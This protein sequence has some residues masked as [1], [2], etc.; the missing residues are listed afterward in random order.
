MQKRKNTGC[1]TYEASLRGMWCVALFALS[2]TSSAIS[3]MV[4]GLPCVSH[5]GCLA[6]SSFCTLT[7]FPWL[8]SGRATCVS[9]WQCCLFPELYGTE[10]CSSRCRCRRDQPCSLDFDCG[11]GEFCAVLLSR[12]D[13]PVCQ[14]CHLCHNDAQAWRGSCAAACPSAALDDNGIAPQL[15]QGS[16]GVEVQYYYVFAA[17]DIAGHPLAQTGFIEASA[18]NGGLV[19]VSEAAVRTWLGD[20]P[21]YVQDALLKP[22][23][24]SRIVPLGDIAARLASVAAQRD[25][26]CPQLQSAAAATSTA[27]SIIAATVPEGCP[28][29]ATANATTFRCPAGQRCSRRAWLSLPADII[30]LGATALLK[31]R[32]VACEPGSYCPEGTYVEEQD[33]LD[34]MAGVYCPKGYYC[35]TPAQKHECPAGY[36]CPARSLTNITCDYQKLIALHLAS[37]QDDVQYTQA[38]VQR[39]ADARMPLRGGYCPAGSSTSDELC[40]AGFFCP[41]PSQQ[42]ICP[43]GHYCRAESIEPRD[44]PHLMLCPAG[45]SAPR[46]WPAAVITFCGLVLSV[47]MMGYCVSIMYDARVQSSLPSKRDQDNRAAAARDLRKFIAHFH[48]G[49]LSRTNRKMWRVERHVLDLCKLKWT[50]PGKAGKSSAAVLECVNGR[51]EDARLSAILGPSG[52]GKSSLLTLLAGRDAHWPLNDGVILINGVKAVSPRDLKY[53]TGFVPQDDIL[54]PELTVGEMINFSAALRLPNAPFRVA[55]PIATTNTGRVDMD[56]SSWAANP[57]FGAPISLS[58]YSGSASGY[59]NTTAPLQANGSSNKGGTGGDAAVDGGGRGGNTSYVGATAGSTNKGQDGGSRSK[60]A[61]ADFVTYRPA[62]ARRILVRD[63]LQMLDLTML[64]DQLVGSVSDKSLSGGQRKRVNIGVELVAR[65]PVLLLDEPTSGLDAAC[66]SDVLISLS[67]V[68]EDHGVNVIMAVHQ[69]RRTI[70]ALFN[71]LMLLDRHGR[72]VYHGDPT[73]ALQYFRSLDYKHLPMD[74]NVADILLD[75]VMGKYYSERYESDDLPVMMEPSTK[76]RAN[77][78]AVA[79]DASESVDGPKAASEAD[80]PSSSADA[81]APP[82]S[83]LPVAGTSAESARP[84]GSSGV[85]L[86]GFAAARGSNIRTP[87]LSERLVKMLR[88]E[89][90]KILHEQG[91]ANRGHKLNR[92]QLRKVFRNFGQK[93]PETDDFVQGILEEAI[94]QRQHQEQQAQQVQYLPQQQELQQRQPDNDCAGRGLHP[95]DPKRMQ[96][97]FAQYQQQFQ[98]QQHNIFPSRSD[99]PQAAELGRPSVQELAVSLKELLAVFQVVLDDKLK[100]E[101]LQHVKRDIQIRKSRLPSGWFRERADS[102]NLEGMPLSARMGGRASWLRHMMPSGPTK[103][104]RNPTD[105]AVAGRTL[106]L[107]SIAEHSAMSHVTPGA[108]ISGAPLIVTWLRTKRSVAGGGGGGGGGRRMLNKS[109]STATAGGVRK[110]PILLGCDQPPPPQQQQQQSAV[111]V[112]GRRPLLQLDGRPPHQNISLRVETTTTTNI[113]AAPPTYPGCAGSNHDHR[114]SPA[115]GNGHNGS[116]SVEQGNVRS[117]YHRTKSAGGGPQVLGMTNCQSVSTTAKVA[118]EAG[119]ASAASTAAAGS[120]SPSSS[121]TWFRRMTTAKLHASWLSQFITFTRRAELQSAR[122]FWSSSMLEAGL[123]MAAAAAVG[124]NQGPD[125]WGPTDV[126]GR[127]IMAM[128]CLAVLAVVQHLSSFSSNSLVLQRERGMGLDVS[129]YF[130]AR[131]VADLPWILIAPVYFSLP[132][133]ILTVPRAPYLPSYYV[134]SL[135]VWWWASGLSY[136]VTVLPLIPAAAAPTAAVLLTLISGALL[137]GWSSPTLVDARG[138]FTEVVLGLSYNR[139]AVET[140]TISELEKYM[141][142]H[143]NIIAAMYSKKGIC[144]LDVALSDINA[145]SF[146]T[147][148]SDAKLTVMWDAIF[149]WVTTPSSSAGSGGTDISTTSTSANS[150]SFIDGLCSEARRD[151]LIILF[152]LGLGLRILAGLTLKFDA[153]LV[154]IILT[155]REWLV[156]ARDAVAAFCCCCCRRWCCPRVG[157]RRWRWQCCFGMDSG[158]TVTGDDEDNVDHAENM[159]DRVVAAAIAAASGA[160]VVKV[161]GD[162]YSGGAGASAEG[163]VGGCGGTADPCRGTGSGLFAADCQSDEA[164][165]EVQAAAISAAA[166]L[167]CCIRDGSSVVH[168]RPLCDL[169]PSCA[170]ATLPATA[171]GPPL[172][173]EQQ[174]QQQQ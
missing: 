124:S 127:I 50:G 85:L 161:Q 97:P 103:D 23:T 31:A 62:E 15:Q 21:T 13:L 136:W 6:G 111:A 123:L 29:N 55:S 99:L 53:V 157:W 86:S 32:C 8:T 4:D 168:D 166:D 46:V 167:V 117:D 60:C 94:R 67:D 149:K 61:K 20:L 72:T 139:W 33:G 34:F 27:N 120:V 125:D 107:P 154:A 43:S 170:P 165:V 5:G 156:Q 52:C 101:H 49:Q 3:T 35:T 63:V 138:T 126:P 109:A 26:L 79:A 174:Q 25:L 118:A 134:V 133:Y 159:D 114:S 119:D 130:V 11:Q 84:T 2:A 12:S 92:A 143:G 71:Q 96:T 73:T 18:Q 115:A 141:D 9:C 171:S 7:S 153:Q 104:R 155:I 78:P 145:G 54:Y 76:V 150:A 148:S 147:A 81:S 24:V 74:E 64:R 65:P 142:S 93:G 91:A 41:D 77:T 56:N 88:V 113:T 16:T 75:I 163:A 172:L 144:R 42:L 98:H 164:V 102:S 17:F 162:C 19:Q 28:C 105:A 66:S 70:Y 68:A 59:S 37:P 169:L 137:N 135:G 22:A 132:Y 40:R 106:S 95:Y 69:P 151:G 110:L 146:G 140:L 58:D 100:V 128:M 82:G 51:F 160:E 14:P 57:G 39:M 38:I 80:P 131:C 10:S 90:D 122:M 36:F 30:T 44:C 152:C 83:S 121:T 89:F 87:E 47:I 45:S 108:A 48:N 112:Q 158:I 173:H 116:G 1:W 129:A